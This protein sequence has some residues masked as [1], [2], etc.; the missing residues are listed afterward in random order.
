M[1][2]LWLAGK[3]FWFPNF[4]VWNRHFWRKQNNFHKDINF[5]KRKKKVLIV[6]HQSQLVDQHGENPNI[7]QASSASHCLAKSALL[8]SSHSVRAYFPLC[9]LPRN[10]SPSQAQRPTVDLTK[11]SQLPYLSLADL[12][13]CCLSA[14]GHNNKNSQR[15]SERQM[16][17][18]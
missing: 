5:V 8:S 6:F 9:R 3:S 4:P 13:F 10:P 7:S 12:C 17:G 2:I 1:R 15:V 16:G 11:P 14:P 18:W